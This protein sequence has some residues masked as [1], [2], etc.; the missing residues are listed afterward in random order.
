M[1]DMFG[2]ACPLCGGSNLGGIGGHPGTVFCYDCNVNVDD[3]KS[4]D[5]DCGGEPIE[6][7]SK[8]ARTMNT[9]CPSCDSGECK[10][11]SPDDEWAVIKCEVCG[12]A[13]KGRQVDGLFFGSTPVRKKP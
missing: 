3:N 4:M 2:D 10:V 6:N 8:E 13:Y 11:L 9:V 5:D 12:F 1:T 7:E